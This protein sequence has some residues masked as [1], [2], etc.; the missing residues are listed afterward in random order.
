[1]SKILKSLGIDVEDLRWYHLSACKNMNI[2]WFY[3]DYESDKILAQTI[4]QVCL[5]CPV[6][7]N[8][9]SEG[10]AKSEKGVWGGIYMDLGRVDKLNNS[11]KTKDIW[12]QLKKLH[13]KNIL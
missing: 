3:D 4:D 1:M 13:G 7:K 11:H 9:Y 5:N 8:C 6:V 12:T 10:V 2:N